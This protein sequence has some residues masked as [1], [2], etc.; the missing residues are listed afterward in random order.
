MARP[1]CHHCGEIRLGVDE[2]RTAGAQGQDCAKGNAG[3]DKRVSGDDRAS[4]D[5]CRGPF[6]YVATTIMLAYWHEKQ[7]PV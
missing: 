4:P 1:E 5:A 2:G 6:C 3:S 7:L